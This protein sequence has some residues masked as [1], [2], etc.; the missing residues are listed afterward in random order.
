MSN[1][2]P[3]HSFEYYVCLRNSHHPGFPYLLANICSQLV[4]AAVAT[5]SVKDKDDKSDT[6]TTHTHTQTHTH[7]HTYIDIYI[8]NFL[9]LPC[10]PLFEM[11]CIDFWPF[12]QEVTFDLTWLHRKWHM[13]RWNV[14]DT[15]GNQHVAHVCTFLSNMDSYVMAWGLH[16]HETQGCHEREYVTCFYMYILLCLG[17]EHS[18]TSCW[19]P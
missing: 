9:Y 15:S 10:C 16:K 6:H 8:C 17:I 3:N 11:Y 7:T 14:K 5:P 2:R 18:T 1:L 4:W 13:Q 19:T 12:A